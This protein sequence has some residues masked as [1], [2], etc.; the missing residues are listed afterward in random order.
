MFLV[1]E[2]RKESMINSSA[3]LHCQ[4][5]RQVYKRCSE[6][7]ASTKECVIL[8]DQLWKWI[9]K[10]SKVLTANNSSKDRAEIKALGLAR[11]DLAK[12][13][14]N[15]PTDMK[16]CLEC[17]KQDH[18]K[19]RHEGSEFRQL[20]QGVFCKRSRDIGIKTQSGFWG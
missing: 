16:M 10:E 9:K 20:S 11:G 13:L 3:L 17:F 5:G 19:L 8:K 4:V 2:D 6:G 1:P 18:W 15:E 12:S 14:F 7:D